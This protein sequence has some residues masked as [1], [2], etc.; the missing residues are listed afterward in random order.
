MVRT[1]LFSLMIC[2]IPVQ[3]DVPKD[4]D[5]LRRYYGSTEGVE[6]RLQQVNLLL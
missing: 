1:N 6:A 5:G 2:R 4:A 3:P